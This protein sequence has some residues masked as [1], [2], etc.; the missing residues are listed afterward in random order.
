LSYG[1]WEGRRGVLPNAVQLAFLRSTPAAVY[2][3]T[4]T[5][6]NKKGRKKWGKETKEIHL[7]PVAGI[8]VGSHAEKDGAK[9]EIGCHNIA[10]LQCSW[11]FDQTPRATMSKN[12]NP[13]A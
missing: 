6:K 3:S 10:L 12:A 4:S 5:R 11:K 9:R 13:A 7:H 2:D 1:R 8:I